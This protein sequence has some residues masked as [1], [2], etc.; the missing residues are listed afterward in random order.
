[1]KK[2]IITITATILLLGCKKSNVELEIEQYDLRKA[3]LG[4]LKDL[5]DVKKDLDYDERTRMIDSLITEEKT[6]I[7]NDSN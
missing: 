3:K 2:V 4:Y 1:M 7:D 5:M 6:R